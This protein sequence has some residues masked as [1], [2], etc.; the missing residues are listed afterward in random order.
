M[1]RKEFLQTVAGAAAFPAISASS[2]AAAAPHSKLERGFTTYSYEL[3]IY[4]RTMSIEDVL[5]EASSIGAYHVEILPDEL[6]GYPHFSNEYVKQWHGWMDKYNMKPNSWTQHIDIFGP[7]R[8]RWDIDQAKRF[9]FPMIRMM[10]QTPLAITE[11]CI[12]YAEKQNVVLLYELHGPTRIDGPD[13]GKIVDL[14][15]KYPNGYLG[16]NPDFSLWQ[17]WPSPARRDGRIRTEGLNP[18]MAQYADAAY[19][20]NETQEKVA[21]EIKKMGGAEP[22]LSYVTFL[23]DG[24][25]DPKKLLALKPYIRRFHAKFWEMTE[26]YHETS[27][28]YE[29]IVPFLIQNGFSGVMASEYEGQRSIM[30]AYPTDEVEQIRRH[31]IMMKRLG[32]V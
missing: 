16:I 30:D 6:P 18:I 29:E 26:D 25:Q 32:V 12:P 3:E 2:A 14:I 22:D 1:T 9:G 21:A 24:Y 27:V 13:M 7:D 4:T 28:P 19:T 5:R 10:L 20:A 8:L 15:K 17:K 11:E 31:Q 23:Y